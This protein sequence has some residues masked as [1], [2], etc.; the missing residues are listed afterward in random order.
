[1]FEHIQIPS[2]LIP[3]DGR[4][5]CGPSLVRPEFVEQLA[6]ES[7]KYLGTSHRQSTVKNKVGSVFTKLRE[8]LEVP[9]DYK[10]AAGNGSASQVWDMTTFSLVEKKAAHFVNGEFSS[11][12]AASTKDSKFVAAHEVKV[13]NGEQPKW[14]EFADC[15]MHAITWNE[16]STG[17]MWKECPK[18]ENS[19]LA[20][21]ATSAAG[22]YGWD[23]SR[24]DLFYF[25]PQKAFGSEGGLWFGFFSPKAVAQIER[26]KKSGR[27][28]P[29]MLDFT[30]A[31]KN[32]EANQTYNTPSLTTFYLLEKQLE[33]FAA[34]G[35][36]KGVAKMAD[37]KYDVLDK[38]IER[39]AEL[40]WYI[41]DANARSRTVC[42]INLDKTIPYDGLTKQLRKFGFL[43][44]DC[45][46]S[47]G[48]NQI[49]ISIFPNV[50]K[51]D[52]VK[53]TKAVDYCLDNRK[54]A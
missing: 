7:K 28:I 6:K 4:F 35:G 45:Y 11:K 29:A 5:G 54:K 26:V 22:A 14:Q 30:Q 40:E 15:D 53:L 50:A 48:E 41:K 27:Y 18:A 12:W 43:D 17:A 42:T 47:L 36:L 52:L 10:I 31:L 13:G 25:S 37:E 23:M 9:A 34:Q 38:W 3:L 39:R 49:R 24:T 32:G 46:R 21:D 20:V 8:Y 1:M 51:D 2:E 16:T 19:L 44:I 33:W